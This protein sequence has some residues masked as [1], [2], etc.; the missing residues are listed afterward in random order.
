MG[1]TPLK[2]SFHRN[3]VFEST[4]VVHAT[5]PDEPVTVADNVLPHQSFTVEP[6]ESMQPDSALVGLQQYG[7]HGE[8]D[9]LQMYTGKIYK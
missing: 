9:D 2:V 4:I 7:V 8:I 1:P 5:T 6:G 3:L